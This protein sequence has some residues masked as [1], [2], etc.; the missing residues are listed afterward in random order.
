ML[1]VLRARKYIVRNKNKLGLLIIFFSSSLDYFSTD[2][3]LNWSS[4]SLRILRS[5]SKHIRFG[6]TNPKRYYIRADKLR[7]CGPPDVFLALDW[8]S[9]AKGD[10][11]VVPIKMR[12]AYFIHLFTHKKDG[13]KCVLR[14]KKILPYFENLYNVFFYFFITNIL[15]WNWLT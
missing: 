2:S 11:V 3:A 8:R 14:A 4:N 7:N 13:Q 1:L 10:S 9:W 5:H 15:I 12:L 6:K